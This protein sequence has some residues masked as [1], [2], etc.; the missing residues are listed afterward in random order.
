MFIISWKYIGFAVILMIAG[1]QSIPEDLYEAAK[2]DGAGFWRQQWSITPCHCSA[3]HHSYLGIHV[4]YRFS[5][6]VRLGLHHLGP[7]RVVYRR[8]VHHGNLHGARRSTRQQLWLRFR[9]GVVIFIISLVIALTYQRF[10]LNRDLEGALTDEKDAKRR[11]K[12]AAKEAAK[13]AKANGNA[14]AVA[15]E[16]VSQ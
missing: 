15:N 4:D 9:R 14:A 1:M 10:V 3:P 6:A 2:V 16:V 7:V 5:S 12:R 11:A 8:N 13:L